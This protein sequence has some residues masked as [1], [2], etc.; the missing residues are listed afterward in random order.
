LRTEV[1]LSEVLTS[2]QVLRPASENA[3]KVISEALGFEWKTIVEKNVSEEIRIDENLVL[4]DSNESL[5]DKQKLNQVKKV[6]EPETD[7]SEDLVT[8]LPQKKTENTLAE[9]FNVD[10]E[11]IESLSPTKIENHFENPPYIGLFNEKWFPAIV[12]LIL[13][14]PT[15]TPKID[16]DS[17]EKKLINLL[18]VNEF[19][20]LYR[21]SLSRGA[22]I[23]L[24][25]SEWM[26]PFWRDERELIDSLGRLLNRHQIK[27]FEVEWQTLPE[28]KIIWHDGS[29]ENIQTETPILIISNFFG[30]NGERLSKIKN[31][32]PFIKLLE[33]AKN[34]R[35][36][37]SV[38]IPMSGKFIPKD[39]GDFVKCSYIWDRTTSPQLVSK[40]KRNR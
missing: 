8:L 30:S 5:T 39:L 12:K 14:F 9:I 31:Y 23:I 2:F 10:W 16:L 22:Q 35:C 3:R 25:V 21:D 26:Q 36:P 18:P 28:K 19:P 34:K 13:G 4:P 6:S 7:A 20:Y 1:S 24:D 17:V 33:L 29:F 38:L 40:I 11:K 37:I 27:V 15:K 32:L